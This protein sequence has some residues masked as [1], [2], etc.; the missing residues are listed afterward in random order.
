MPFI[1]RL[2]YSVEYALLRA[3]I[4]LIRLM[5]LDMAVKFSAK[6]WRLL[7]SRGRRHQRAL[8]NL[9]IAFPDKT[10]EQRENIALAMWGN[11]GRVMAETMQMDRILQ[12]PE[13]ITVLNPHVLK[14]Y[15]GKIGAAICASMHMGNWE[16]AM[17]PLAA[18]GMKPAGVYRIVNNPFVD[19]YL[20]AQRTE[21]YPGGLFAKGKKQAELCGTRYRAENR[22]LCAPGR[23]TWVFS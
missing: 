17:W 22:L 19:A 4:E 9:Q 16:L 1:K 18:A 7:A 12:Q 2:R 11:L 14:R 15:Q 20:R 10:P 8:K 5:P 23:T 13:R 3:I 21:L 6:S